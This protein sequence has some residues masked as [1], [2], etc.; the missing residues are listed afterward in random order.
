[1]ALTA[2]RMENYFLQTGA[3]ALVW[4]PVYTEAPLAQHFLQQPEEKAPFAHKP[5]SALPPSTS[6]H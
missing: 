2:I 6:P 5:P 3:A 4:W 1:M